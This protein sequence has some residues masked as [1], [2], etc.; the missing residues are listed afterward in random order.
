[1]AERVLSGG[2][3]HLLP[4]ALVAAGLVASHALSVAVHG[5]AH[6]GD[7]LPCALHCLHQPRHVVP[8]LRAVGR[9]QSSERLHLEKRAGWHRMHWQIP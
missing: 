4:D 2:G 9:R 8:Q 3:S 7:D 1:M 6:P 5:I